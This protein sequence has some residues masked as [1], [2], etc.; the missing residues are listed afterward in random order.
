MKGEGL[1]RS[2]LQRGHIRSLVPLYRRKSEKLI[3]QKLLEL[4]PL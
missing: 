3:F 4:K 2:S 1:I